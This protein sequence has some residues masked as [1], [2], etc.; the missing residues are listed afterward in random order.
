MKND[1]VRLVKVH[2]D[3]HTV[4]SIQDDSIDLTGKALRRKSRQRVTQRYA[5]HVP[6][7][8]TTSLRA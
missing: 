3:V 5:P 1:R 6:M 4:L 2:D 8:I 7:A